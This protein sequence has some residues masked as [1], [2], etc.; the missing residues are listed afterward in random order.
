[1]ADPVR[2]SLPERD[3]VSQKNFSEDSVS[4]RAS[5]V[6]PLL[7]VIVTKKNKKL[8]PQIKVHLFSNK[9]LYFQSLNIT[10]ANGVGH[11]RP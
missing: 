7:G 1:M 5:V 10:L 6:F 4:F 11:S 3:A 2:L 8:V 9:R